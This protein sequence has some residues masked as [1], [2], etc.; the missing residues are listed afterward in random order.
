MALR[1][2]MLIWLDFVSWVTLNILIQTKWLLMANLK[3]C[4]PDLVFVLSKSTI[5]PIPNFL[6][7]AVIMRAILTIYTLLRMLLIK[8]MS[9]APRNR[10]LI[11]I[12]K[13]AVS[14]KKSLQSLLSIT[15]TQYWTLKKNILTTWSLTTSL[16]IL[17]WPKR[18][19]KMQRT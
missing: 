13:A 16:S 3:V 12:L 8:Y 4:H 1:L 14:T 6:G 5:I 2:L 7:S 18:W 17:D 15:K 11:L 9:W 10:L 19:F